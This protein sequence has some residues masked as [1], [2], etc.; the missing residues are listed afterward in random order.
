M[1]FSGFQRYSCR[2][3]QRDR[4]RCSVHWSSTSA[5]WRNMLGISRSVRSVICIFSTQSESTGIAARWSAN[6]FS[7]QPEIRTPS[8][9]T[10]AAKA[11]AINPGITRRAKERPPLMPARNI[12]LIVLVEN[13][14]RIGKTASAAL[15]FPD[16][17]SEATEIAAEWVS[18]KPA[19]AAAT[20]MPV[21]PNHSRSAAEATRMLERV[22]ANLKPWRS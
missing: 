8:M 3:L 15:I 1:P 18:T 11:T 9:P 4:I 16:A 13:P 5:A 6:S 19:R 7:V 14:A 22:K 21:S 12:L 2:G 10:Q 17:T 20:I